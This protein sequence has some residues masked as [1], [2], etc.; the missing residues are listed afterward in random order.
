MKRLKLNLKLKSKIQHWNGTMN[1]SQISINTN[2]CE[3]NT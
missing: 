3:K 1:V 2:M